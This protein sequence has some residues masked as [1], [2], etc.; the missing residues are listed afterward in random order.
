ME[1]MLDQI[2]DRYAKQTAKKEMR[3]VSK[4]FYKAVRQAFK[5]GWIQREK[6]DSLDFCEKECTLYNTEYRCRECTKS[7]FDGQIITDC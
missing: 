1:G 4:I 2:A 6:A 3:K 5:D 7:E